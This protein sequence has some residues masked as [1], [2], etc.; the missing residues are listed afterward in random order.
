MPRRAPRVELIKKS[1]VK[2]LNPG[3][4]SSSECLKMKLCVIK[5]R[6]HSMSQWFS[7]S[8]LFIKLLQR[9]AA[10]PPIYVPATG[11]VWITRRGE[12]GRVLLPPTSHFLSR[13]QK[14]G[15]HCSV[16]HRIVRE[17]CYDSWWK[18]F[19]VMFL[20]FLSH[21]SPYYHICDTCV[22]KCHNE[23]TYN[24]ITLKTISFISCYPPRHKEELKYVCY[25]ILFF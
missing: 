14:Y 9:S 13:P 18:W 4:F 8:S 1:A 2:F 11:R 20:I 25:F 23:H 5:R 21:L 15:I 22:H 3:I 10:L 6:Q 12:D 7:L 16:R 24:H 17:H 19:P